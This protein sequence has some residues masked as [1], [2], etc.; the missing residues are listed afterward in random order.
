[1]KSVVVGAAVL[2]LILNA[3][4]PIEFQA[5]AGILKPHQRALCSMLI[6]SIKV[7]LWL[8]ERPLG[9][10]FSANQ[11]ADSGSAGSQPQSFVLEKRLGSGFNGTVYKVQNVSIPAPFPIAGKFGNQYLWSQGVSPE[12]AS[13]EREW[14]DS[15]LIEAYRDQAKEPI[16]ALPILDRLQTDLGLMLVKPLATGLFISDIK[17]QFG[18][19]TRNL[20]AEMTASLRQI[21]LFAQKLNR[22]VQVERFGTVVGFKLDIKPENLVWITD[23]RILELMNLSKPQF[24]LLEATHSRHPHWVYSQQNMS[25]DQ[26]LNVFKTYLQNQ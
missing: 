26:Y 23:A 25:L 11:I 4:G 18:T 16:P 22:D 5:N 9:Q 10:I 17:K 1:M 6:K 12:E 3:L 13:L 7:D 8:S 21:F 15:L 19:R 24:V 20:P 14:E 2:I